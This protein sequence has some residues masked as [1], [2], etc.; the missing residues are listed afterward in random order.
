MQLRYRYIG[1][2]SIATQRN[3]LPL[4]LNIALLQYRTAE[5]DAE[6]AIRALQLTT[7]QIQYTI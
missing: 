3:V 4:K 6:A 1:Q 2:Y 5:P 7:T